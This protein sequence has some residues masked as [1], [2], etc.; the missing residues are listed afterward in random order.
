MQTVMQIHVPEKGV[1]I[2]KAQELQQGLHIANSITKSDN[3]IAVVGVINT[4]DHDVII[5]NINVA[6]EPIYKFT[7]SMGNTNK[8]DHSRF[9]KLKL[10]LKC[11][12]EMDS[13]KM[14]YLHKMCKNY[15]DVFMLPDDKLSHTNARRFNL[16][17]IDDA[18]I[19]LR[20][21]RIP[22]KHKQEVSKQV[23][24]LLQNDIIEPS[25]SPFNSPLL[26]VP[27]KS[28]DNHGEK[29]FRLCIDY[30]KLNK[31]LVPY[32]FP[33]PRI[34]EILDQLG[35]A[36]I[37][38]TLDLSQG[39][40]QVMIDKKDREKTAFSTA[41]G[42]YQYK[43]CPFGLKTLPGF[44]QSMLNSILT[45]L[46]GVTCFVYIDDVVI[47]AKDLEEHDR[48][49]TDVLNRFRQYNLKLNPEK[50]HFM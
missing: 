14:W 25:I 29:L 27:K 42:H 37:F 39:F 40:H 44:F 26:L 43:R 9:E 47:F 24:K 8:N 32:Q 21:Y 31:N 4:N 48:K 41:F 18:I 16:P 49:L 30:R 35:K 19:N 36:K 22:E 38:S 34:D 10:S 2:C 12:E 11:N 13:E 6:T 17:L 5:D 7:Q 15:N 23:N 1:R 45:G 33:L 50:F 20:Q 3:G 46:Q 28:V